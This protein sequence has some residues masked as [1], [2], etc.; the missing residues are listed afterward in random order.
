[1]RKI[2]LTSPVEILA[3]EL[4]RKDYAACDLT[5]FNLSGEQVTSVEAALT[6]TDENGEEIARVIH[7]ARSLDGAPGKAFIMTI[8]TENMTRAKGWEATVDKV[9]FDNSSIW[10][11][12]KKN[13]LEYEPNE[14]EPSN[15]L[16]NLR[17]VA[18]GD[19]VGYPR[20]EER[21]W[22]CVC[23]RPN[24]GQTAVCARCQRAKK[25]VFTFFSAEAVERAVAEHESR[26]SE[27]GKQTVAG[28]SEMQLQREKEHIENTRKRRKI[29]LAA[30]AAVVLLAGLIVGGTLVMPKLKYQQAV[31]AFENG[32]F[33]KA[34]EAF[35]AMGDYGDS[36]DYV[37]KSRYEAAQAL[38]KEGGAE[39]VAAAKEAFIALGD[40]GD[41]ALMVTECDYEQAL[42]LL[43]ADDREGAAEMFTALGDYQ[44]S[45]KQLKRIAYMD[46]VDLMNS[47]E[48]EQ[49][50]AAFAAMEGY[51]DAA[52][53][54]QECW[55]REASAA[56]DS[57]DM[58]AALS[59]FAEVPNYK[60]AADKSKQAHYMRAAALREQGDADAAAKEFVLAGDYED[61]AQQA[62]ESLYLPGIAAYEAGQYD[63]AAE[64]LSG[65]RGFEDAEEKWTI[66]TY[67]AAKKALK[68]LEY[69]RA[70]TLLAELPEDYED[71]AT[72]RQ[73]CVYRPAAE[74]YQ[75]GEYETALNLFSQIADYSDAQE[76]INR[77]RYALA[78]AYQAQ[79]DWEKAIEQY[80]ILGDYDD[81][82]K[83]LQA[84]QYMQA[85]G[86]LELGTAEGY[87]QAMDA[88]AA[89]DGYS[90]SADK[91]KEARLGQADLLLA[92]GNYAD[93]RP[94]FA[95]LGAF[96]EAAQRVQACDYARA[97]D[98]Y[99]QGKLDEAAELYASVG[100]YEDA[101]DKAQ[102]V[103]YELGAKAAQSGDVL[104]AARYYAQ[105]GSHEDAQT[106]AETLFDAYYAEAA[107]QAQK[108][109]DSKDYIQCVSVLRALE[110]GDLPEKYAKLPELYQAA[111]F[112][113]GNQLYD[114]G[115][116]YA[117]LP[118]YREIPGYRTVD[119]RLQR[120]CYLILGTWTDL[121]GTTYVFSEDGT[122][123]IGGET[124]Y[125]AVENTTLRTGPSPE[126][127]SD[128]HRLSG[129]TLRNA[130]LFDG[131]SGT[132]ITI[133]LT[134][135]E[136]AAAALSSA[137]AET[138]A[139][140]AGGLQQ[141]P[142][143]E[144]TEE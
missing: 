78:A 46:A 43:A 72:L 14:L 58:E 142:L 29:I 95:E 68:D 56:L 36:A 96:G 16:N 50:R 51:E 20:D 140:A 5:L 86:Y 7:R 18:G 125:F 137:E 55:Y 85:C 9:W 80:T 17:A 54:V 44:D 65:V 75:R 21:L 108:A 3:C 42:L 113:A 48:F 26:L 64:L 69:N 129:V 111:C 49:A 97:A 93:A 33:Q 138:G 45:A 110:L 134:K 38:L 77:S 52:E 135:D 89:L 130:W 15:A 124:M 122:L 131:R 23:G 32:D 39:Q 136:E 73:E 53:Q 99:T 59:L 61:A 60:D 109:Y 74:A 88:F 123:T 10:R 28:S 107:E 105:A 112:E 143:P 62:N 63:R 141:I 82:A 12:N 121:N 35:L 27:Q 98:L 126:A 41:A 47:G 70:S 92:A 2:D 81:A 67:E 100:S 91:V 115:E 19:A 128:T 90:D 133:Y 31:A 34:E 66:S 76:Q 144:S 114:A 25:D 101:Q 127:L 104:T 13:T 83:Q 132:E 116:P 102:S 8:P 117:A 24:D 30:A 119:S 139:E 57:G 87:Q 22:L 4:P 71:V 84:A 1:M 79:G 6:L 118:Y 103:W 106:Q 11:R 120:A 37:L 40:Y 94:I